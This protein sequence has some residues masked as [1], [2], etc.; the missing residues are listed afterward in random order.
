MENE[1]TGTTTSGT[2]W[3]STSYKKHNHHDTHDCV[4]SLRYCKHCDVVYCEKCWKEWKNNNYTWWYGYNNYSS[5]GS[6][7]TYKDGT[8]YCNHAGEET[9]THDHTK[10]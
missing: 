5:G 10:M 1:I 3:G 9:T 2:Y 8:V 7:P 4:H 6:T